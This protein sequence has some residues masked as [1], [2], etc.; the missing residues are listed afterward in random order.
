MISGFVPGSL[1]LS[2][3]F[4]PSCESEGAPHIFN[5]A[6][7]LLNLPDSGLFCFQLRTLP[8]AV[9]KE[10]SKMLNY[11]PSDSFRGLFCCLNR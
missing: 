7:F 2:L 1:G 10:C 5:E 3:I 11:S 9:L 4:Y 8:S 6:L